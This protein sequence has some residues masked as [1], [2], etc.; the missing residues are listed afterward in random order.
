MGMEQKS[1]STATYILL[2]VLITGVIAVILF[3]ILDAVRGMRQNPAAIVTTGSEDKYTGLAIDPPVQ[4]ADFTLSDQRGQ[5]FTFSSLRG[6][7]VVMFFGFTHC[8]DYCPTTLQDFTIIKR[9]L[10]AAAE[11]VAFMFISVD[12][13]RDTP[14]V[15][16]E[17]INR[18][19]SSFIGLTGTAE[20]IASI[21]QPFGL[22]VERV[23]VDSAL[24][25]TINHTVSMFLID[26]DGRWV[27]RI[28]FGTAP[29]VIAAQVRNMLTE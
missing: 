3:F 22:T 21:G 25:Y 28:S 9:E 13:E 8:P 19:D 11:H 14:E 7:A 24:G 29:G 20:A 2:G 18:F 1:P 27:R 26:R 4:L 6:R 15:I 23:G 16:A 12:G 17:Y 5:A 10:G